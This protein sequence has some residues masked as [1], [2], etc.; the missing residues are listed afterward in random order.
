MRSQKLQSETKGA[1]QDYKPLYK[2]PGMNPFLAAIFGGWYIRWRL[3]RNIKIISKK[4][5]L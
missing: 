1:D 2:I 5:T 4:S 3:R